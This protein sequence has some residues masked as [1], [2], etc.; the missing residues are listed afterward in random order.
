MSPETANILVVEDE[1]SMR[2][3][4]T[5]LLEGEGYDV[6]AASDGTE[7]MDFIEKDIF[8][9]IITDIKM[10]GATGFEILKKSKDTSPETIVIM[11]TAFGTMESGVEA[12]KLGAYDYIHKP[13][14]IDE[15]RHIIRNAMDKRRLS[16]K[17]ALLKQKVPA[18]EV[19][20]IIGKSAPMQRL[21]NMIP[22]VAQSNSNALVTGQSGTGKELVAQ[23]LHTLSPRAEKTFVAINCASIPEGLLESEL[24][25]HMKGS[26]TGAHLNKQGLFEVADEGSLFL[27]EI[28][29][30]PL[31]LQS[32]LLRAIEHGSFRRVGGTTDINC[33]VRVIAATN[34]NLKD[35]VKEGGFREDLFYRLNVIPLHVP[36]LRERKD[37]IPLLVDHFLRKNSAGTRQFSGSAM[38]V[39]M[40]YAW[41]GNIREL[42]NLVAQ[43]LILSDQD[44]ITDSD[45]PEELSIRPEPE[46]TG[47]FDISDGMDLD[48]ELANIERKYL[49]AALKET[50]GNKTEAAKLLGL[51][52]RSLR[53]K[54][55]KYDIKGL[56]EEGQDHAS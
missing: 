4:L 26:F 27:D 32:K 20:N 30:M 2:E 28:G 24:F 56:E 46:K 29:L 38:K 54:L 42:E 16:V 1:G 45:M 12:M 44:I 53:H 9:L 23:A 15:I 17:Y 10:P 34:K 31:N 37:D 18:F 11:I 39:L 21:L 6:T 7:G 33:N 35:A 25:G 40:D 3:V 52:F 47:A 22:R 49:L 50:G 36:L 8:D 43:M 13:F 14:K 19:E 55:T 51:K 41:P 5:M 48:E